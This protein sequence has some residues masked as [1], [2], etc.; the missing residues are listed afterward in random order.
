[1]LS[2]RLPKEV[3]ATVSKTA[4]L[5]LLLVPTNSSAQST[6]T[7]RGTVVD[8]RKSVVQNATI[9]ATNLATSLERSARTD[10]QGFYLFALKLLF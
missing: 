3:S 1:M 7:L 4:F 10:D 9:V 6:A 2:P 5:L 8:P